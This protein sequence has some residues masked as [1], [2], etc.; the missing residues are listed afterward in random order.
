MIY[1][2][3]VFDLFSR[4]CNLRIAMKTFFLIFP[5]SFL[6]WHH[7]MENR[8]NAQSEWT[9]YN[10]AAWLFMDSGS[11]FYKKWILKRKWPSFFLNCLFIEQCKM[12]TLRSCDLQRDLIGLPLC[13]HISLFLNW[14]GT[15]HVATPELVNLFFKSNFF[16]SW[17]EEYLKCM[18]FIPDTIWLCILQTSL[19]LLFILISASCRSFSASCTTFLAFLLV[20]CDVFCADMLSETLLLIMCQVWFHLKW[21]ET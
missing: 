16:C 1:F 11:D 20:Q 7:N 12:L 2:S 17:I 6:Y 5:C 4:W 10:A 9:D 14:A 8:W 3:P 18:V 21:I 15:Q 13:C 19:S